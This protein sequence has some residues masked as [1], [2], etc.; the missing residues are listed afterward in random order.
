M[1][2]SILEEAQRIIFGQRNADYGHPREN[3][4]NIAD[5]WT[6]FKGVEFTP[7]DVAL[8]MIQVKVARLESGVY[9]RDSVTDIAG[10][11]GTIERLQEPVEP[12]KP[13][14]WDSL[15]QLRW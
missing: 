5:L 9:H 8:M 12:P 6:A 4:K 10:Y 1:S 14:E 3:F 2:E 11:A 15:D 13:R 7:M